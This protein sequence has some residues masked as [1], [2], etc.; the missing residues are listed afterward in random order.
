MRLPTHRASFLL[1][2]LFVGGCLGSA[3]QECSPYWPDIPFS[4]AEIPLDPPAIHLA[5]LWRA[6]G[7]A[8]GE[9]IAYPASVAVSSRGA[10][11]I[12]DFGLAQVSVISPGGEWLGSWGRQ[13]RGPGELT[14]PVAA[15]WSGDTLLIFDID[16]AKVVRYVDAAL[17]DEVRVPVEFIP[18][19]ATA[20]SIE[21]VAVA[22]DGTVLLQQPLAASSSSD[23]SILAILAQRPGASH[24]DTVA[25]ATVSHIDLDHT[26][27][28]QPGTA[29]PLVAVG[30]NGW[31]AQTASDGSYRATW[32]DGT[33]QVQLCAPEPPLPLT[34]EERGA[35]E[36]PQGF[37]KAA[38]AVESARPPATLN[39]V[40]RILVSS[41][42]DL[43]FDRRRPRPFLR[44]Q[45]FGVAGGTMDV[46]GSGG[47]YRGRA[48]IPDRVKI[49]GVSDSIAVGIEFSELD[50]VTVV[51]YRLVR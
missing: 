33:V 13:G 35:K 32:G 28:V 19:G 24:P 45:Q 1:V 9:E 17:V 14:M 21:C 4:A 16:Q 26:R 20:G 11:A 34:P 40:G 18:P 31:L 6:G 10:V 15:N 3:P 37:E 36:T 38:A 39:R 7:S 46:F 43:W 47:R 49:Q 8:A 50:E 30:P 23:S 48:L 29:V 12:V 25:S 27:M 22:A 42:G 5:E 44:E 51:A 41:S 2:L